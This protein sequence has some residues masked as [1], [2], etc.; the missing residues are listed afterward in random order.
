M[1][2]KPERRKPSIVEELRFAG[3]HNTIICFKKCFHILLQFQPDFRLWRTPT[4][5]RHSNL[6][7]IEKT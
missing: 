2:P 7:E 3:Q 1:L 6:T 4:F 5:L